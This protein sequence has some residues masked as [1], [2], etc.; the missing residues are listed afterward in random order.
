MQTFS[1]FIKSSAGPSLFIFDIDE[2]L[3]RTTAKIHVVDSEGKIV[4]KLSNQQ[5]NDFNLTPGYSYDFTE[6]RDSAKFNAESTPMKG[7]ILNMIRIQQKIKL[8]LTPGSKVIM[9]TAREDFDDKDTFL[10]T[11]K[12]QGIDTDAAHVHRSGNLPGNDAPALKKLVVVRQ[13][14]ADGKFKQVHCYD[15]SATNLKAFLTLRA[16]YPDIR[17]FAWQVLRTGETRKF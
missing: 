5:F 6:F 12:K 15:D 8:N 4:R 1:Q 2:T 9:N 17:F 16:E 14:L 13:Y 7:M 10:D 3:F 11:F